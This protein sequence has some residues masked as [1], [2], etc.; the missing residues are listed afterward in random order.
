MVIFSLVITIVG[1][2]Y[3]HFVDATIE[4]DDQ[5]VVRAELQHKLAELQTIGFWL[6]DLDTQAPQFSGNT[7]DPSLQWLANLPEGVHGKLITTFMK[8]DEGIIQPFSNGD[9]EGDMPRR[10]VQCH[11]E[12]QAGSSLLV[13]ENILLS[14][15]PTVASLKGMLHLLKTA[16][17]IYYEAHAGYP[18]RLSDLVPDILEEIPNDPYTSELSKVTHFEEAQ[19]W[20]YHVNPQTGI[21]TLFA[22]SHPPEYYP[23]MAVSLLGLN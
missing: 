6:W 3:Q 22:W 19:D 5:R 15:M 9:F 17:T 23:D 12:L 18:S 20:A 1:V 21:L 7:Q 14:V 13:S 4:V 8:Q 10:L 16:L 2:T 11:V